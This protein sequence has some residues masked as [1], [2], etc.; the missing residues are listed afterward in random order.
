MS[1]KQNPSEEPLSPL[2]F[3]DR[4]LD[5][6][7]DNTAVE[8]VDSGISYDFSKL[9]GRV[10]S[11]A[12]SLPNRPRGERVAFL[13]LNSP[14]LLE[15]HF[16]V[17]LANKVLVAINYRLTPKEILYIIRHSGS[18]VLFYD[19]RLSGQVSEIHDGLKKI[20]SF[21]LVNIPSASDEK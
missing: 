7:P 16:A 21:K 9:G 1:G 13:S 17:P 18:K 14:A 5:I 3:L 15:A 11:L 4:S 8:D 19:T 10:T 12:R 6:F 2:S 20:D